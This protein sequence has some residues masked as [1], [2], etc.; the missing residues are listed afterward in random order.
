[1]PK[2]PKAYL[3][4]SSGK[5]A[6]FALHEVRR[7]GLANVVGVL[8]TINE[9]SG[10]VQ[11]HGVRQELLDRQIDALGLPAIKVMLPNPCPNAVY[12][13]RMEEAFGKLR[14]ES[15]GHIV[16][17]DLFLED[18]RAYREKQLSGTGLEPLFPVWAI[19]TATLARQM[20]ASGIR[21]KLTCVD[22]AQIDPQFAGREFD[23]RLLSD[24]PSSADPCGENGEFHT[25]VYAGPMFQQPLALE[26]GEVVTREPFVWRDL[27][28]V[29]EAAIGGQTRGL[30][31]GLTP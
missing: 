4:W 25:C 16:Y 5:D 12:E 21:A 17:G 23:A 24:L 29:A 19:P 20:I 7:L 30:T 8:T 1:M 14:S 15:V 13:A 2:P 31:P 11:S 9:A 3:S 18:I 6:A 28:L 27:Q 26:P 10:R 22:S